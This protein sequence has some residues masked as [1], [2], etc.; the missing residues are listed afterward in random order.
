MRD[1]TRLFAHI[2]EHAQ[3]PIPP[4]EK[5]SAAAGLNKMVKDD[6][7]LFAAPTELRRSGRHLG[8][9]FDSFLLRHRKPLCKVLELHRPRHE[10]N[11]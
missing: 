2:A 3:E 8:K 9:F 7:G 10:V 11:Q 6:R 5:L 4:R 1:E